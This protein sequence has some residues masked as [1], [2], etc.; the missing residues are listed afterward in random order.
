[1]DKNIFFG[2]HPVLEALE[3]DT[4]ITKVYLSQTGDFKRLSLI[5]KAALKRDISVSKVPPIKLDNL[6]KD[7]HQ[8]V[9][10]MG[11][12][13]KY[14]DLEVLIG[15][16]LREDK[17]PLLLYLDGVTDTRNLGGIARSA[18][19]LG[20]SGIVLPSQGS[21]MVTEDTVRAS[22]GAI[23]KIPVA[24]VSNSKLALHTAVSEGFTIA[25]VTEKGKQPMSEFEYNQPTMLL[26]GGEGKGISPGLIK[27]S[28][29]HGFIPMLG[30]V[31]SLNVS[32]A[33]GIACYE[34]HMQK[35]ARS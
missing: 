21:A 31:S 26:F 32:V 14:W 34:L 18:A 8:G 3:G 22:A 33:V 29:Y 13:I 12:P 17:Q 4:E 15:K 20:V 27:L 30:G 35:L 7:N 24:R 6:C 1:M 19:C 11:S 2:F 10:A 16:V 25:A 9:V 28:Q 5:E 23:L